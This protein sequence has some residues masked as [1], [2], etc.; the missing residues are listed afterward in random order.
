MNY[1]KTISIFSL[2]LFWMAGNVLSY[3][4]QEKWQIVLAPFRT[5]TP[6][7]DVSLKEILESSLDSS[8][9]SISD[10]EVKKDQA[11][12]LVVGDRDEALLAGRDLQGDVIVYGEY[13]VQQNNLVIWVE[14]LDVLRDQIKLRTY[15][16]GELSLD[17]F[18]TIDAATTDIV[19]KIREAL[20]EFTTESEVEIQ[21][22]RQTV[23]EQQE[24][25]LKRMFYTHLG[26]VN[27]LGMKD[28]DYTYPSY[29]FTGTNTITN[30]Q[31]YNYSGRFPLSQLEFGLTFRF[32][33]VRL[34]TA[35]TGLPG[36]PQFN[37]ALDPRFQLLDRAPGYFKVSLTWYPK[38]LQDRFAIG[39]GWAYHSPVTSTNFWDN[40]WQY[41]IVRAFDHSVTI[42]LFYHP[43]RNLEL[44][45][46]LKLPFFETESIPMTI[47]S[48][49]NEHDAYTMNTTMPALTLSATWFFA[50][51]IGIKGRV[52]YERGTYYSYHYEDN[53][54]G[55]DKYAREQGGGPDITTLALYLG[56]VYR[57]DFL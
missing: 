50:R 37:G 21:K 5:L 10:F 32:A 15:Y 12:R 48:N 36:V 45:A 38:F 34:D 9:R 17:L 1:K 11:A 56:L 49:E 47:G 2:V 3:A 46:S 55:G 26:V 51:N 25:K 4:S 23:Y 24:L 44:E 54:L 28:I 18:D 16:T 43:S 14:V 20:P 39:T 8:L 42:F 31:N 19:K 35:F 52:Y 41:N 7:A 53:N 40:E 29:D 30:I 57:A 6:G 27:E 22:V 33:N 13:Y